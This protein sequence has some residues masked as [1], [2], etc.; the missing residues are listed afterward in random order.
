MTVNLNLMAIKNPAVVDML[1]YLQNDLERVQEELVSCVQSS[2]EL[3]TEMSTHLI[4]AGGK[5][6]RP[7][8]CIVASQ[9]QVRDSHPASPEVIKGAVAMELVHIGTLCHDDVM[10]EAVTRRSMPSVNA[11]WGNRRAILAG[12]YLLSRSGEVAA[13]LGSEAA[14]LV[15]RTITHLCEGQ[16]VELEASYDPNR[17]ES[18]YEEAIAGKTAALLSASCRIGAMLAGSPSDMADSLG[19]FGHAYGMAF[20]IVD[21][22]LDLQATD[23]KLGKPAGND[24]IEGVYTLPVLRAL[25]DPVVGGELRSLLGRRIGSSVRDKACELVLGTSGIEEARVVAQSWADRAQSMLGSLPESV[26]AGSLRTA[27][28]YL[29]ARLE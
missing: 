19:D 13:S 2:S 20:Q 23:E 15:A 5:K 27:A 10:D 6:V 4:T 17:S 28:G 26:A 24:L 29:F 3:T 16:I 18:F 21:D 8:L 1:P 11:Q 7:I 14:A 12:D 22:I 9:V 25:G